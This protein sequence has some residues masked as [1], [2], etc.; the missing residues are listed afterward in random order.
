M[1]NSCTTTTRIV[2]F[3]IPGVDPLSICKDCKMPAVELQQPLKHTANYNQEFM[4]LYCETSW[5]GLKN[6]TPPDLPYMPLG[7]ISLPKPPKVVSP[8]QQPDTV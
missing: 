6:V 3:D 1:G 8:K 7:S 5:A 4:C 2:P